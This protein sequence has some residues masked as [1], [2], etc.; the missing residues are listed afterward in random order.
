MYQDQARQKVRELLDHED[1]I[2]YD[3]VIS[4][5]A[6]SAAG[7]NGEFVKLANELATLLLNYEVALVPQPDTNPSITL[8]FH[9]GELIG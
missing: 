4:E 6:N 1:A 5:L 2:R 7:V 8:V 9:K 3:V